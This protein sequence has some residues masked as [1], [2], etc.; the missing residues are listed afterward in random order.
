MAFMPPRFLQLHRW[1]TNSY[2]TSVRVNGRNG[3]R[4]TQNKPSTFPN[5]GGSHL[6]SMTGISWRGPGLATS[7]PCE[8]KW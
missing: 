8:L 5:H 2:E 4:N 7:R 3:R 6:C 1:L